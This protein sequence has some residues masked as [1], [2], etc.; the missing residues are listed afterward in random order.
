MK[1]IITYL[2][3]SQFPKVIQIKCVTEF[4][5]WLLILIYLKILLLELLVKLL[6]TTNKVVLAGETRGPKIKRRNNKQ[7]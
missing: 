1:K 4:Q 5:I 2:Q 6:T 7:S 3:V